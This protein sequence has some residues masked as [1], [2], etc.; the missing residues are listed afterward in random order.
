M[1]A[2]T[3]YLEKS[4]ASQRRAVDFQKAE[5]KRYEDILWAILNT[6]EFLFNH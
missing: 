5:R 1:K 2:A 3:D 6:K 4:R